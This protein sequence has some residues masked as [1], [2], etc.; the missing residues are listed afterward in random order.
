MIYP[1]E[2]RLIRSSEAGQ[3]LDMIRKPLDLPPAV[4][5]AFVADTQAGQNCL[6]K[7]RYPCS[8]TS[9]TTCA[10]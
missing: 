2:K 10:G 4:A 1:E 9:T 7:R 8:S 6:L 3:V 5:Q